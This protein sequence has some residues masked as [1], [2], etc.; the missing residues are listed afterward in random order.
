MA[1]RSLFDSR[2]LRLVILFA[3]GAAGS[4]GGGSDV[5]SPP[6][7]P[8]PPAVAS[9]EVAPSLL[10][11]AVGEMA[12]LTVTL[13]AADGK[14]LAGRTVTWTS[15]DQAIAT[16]SETGIVTAAAAGTATITATS[17][18]VNGTATV[19]VTVTQQP[20]ATVEVTPNNGNF[21]AV[22]GT[23]QFTA[24]V[25]AADGSV[26]V[27]RPVTW[28]T[29]NAAVATVSATGLV[30]GVAPGTATITATSE[31]VSGTATVTVTPVAGVIR[32]WL[33]GTGAKPSDWSTD[34]NW[35]PAGAPIALDTVRVPVA[36]NS[37]VLSEDVQIARL[38]VA[39]GTLRNAG[40]RLKIKAP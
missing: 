36:A 28:T 32:T 4:C 10:S 40:Y 13:K 19:T 11:M 22:G 35:N 33:G 38:I 34:G 7:P 37:A 20:V 24:T 29:S 23:L 26:L 17:E 9:V 30:T 31:G 14:V 21:V 27:G 8:G 1:V 39:G 6:D 16:V 2:G 12:Q 5:T 3:A 25:K 18:G 15:S